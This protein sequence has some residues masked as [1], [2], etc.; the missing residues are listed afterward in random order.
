[1][2]LQESRLLQFATGADIWL[3]GWRYGSERPVFKS[4]V[5][6]EGLRTSLHI[7]EAALWSSIWLQRLKFELFNILSN[8]V[9]N[10]CYKVFIQSP[11]QKRSLQML[12]AVIRFWSKVQLV[13]AKLF[14]Y[15]SPATK[16]GI[17]T[18]KDKMLRRLDL[19]QRPKGQQFES[20][21]K[22]S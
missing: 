9:I 17:Q 2:S 8:A 22:R 19:T 7:Q 5:W 15:S 21:Q 3:S 1:M 18:N 4:M 20:Q 14:F 10:F 16:P 13:V 11:K 12:P 6:K